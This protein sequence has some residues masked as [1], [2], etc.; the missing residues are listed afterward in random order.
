MGTTDGRHLSEHYIQHYGILIVISSDGAIVGLS[1]NISS[2]IAR[3]DTLAILGTSFSEFAEAHFGYSAQKILLTVDKVRFSQSPRQLILQSI[4]GQIYYLYIYKHSSEVFLEWE[5][6]RRKSISAHEMDELGFLFEKNP[7]EIWNALCR[8]VQKLIQYENVLVWQVLDG[9]EG[10]I[11]AEY[12]KANRTGLKD[13]YFSAEFMP[14]DIVSFY[15]G[16]PYRYCPNTFAE[17]QHFLSLQPKLQLDPCSYLRFPHT[18]ESYLQSMGITSAIVYPIIVRDT[19]WGIILAH[20]KREKHI[21]RQKRKLCSFVVQNAIGKFEAIAQQLLLE[22]REQMKAL[23]LDLKDRLL[24]SDTAN[25]AIAE[26]MPQLCGLVEADGLVLYH[27]GDMRTYGTCPTSIQI[28]QIIQ[29]LHRHSDTRLLQD[30]RFV[31][32]YQDR[33]DHPIPIAGVMALEIGKGEDHYAIWLRKAIVQ[34]IT[35]IGD[36]RSDQTSTRRK[37]HNRS[38]NLKTRAVTIDNLALPWG[39]EERTFVKNLSALIENALAAKAQEQEKHKQEMTSLNKELEMLTFTLSHDLKNPLSIVKM[40]VQFL[41]TNDKLTQEAQRKWYRSILEGVDHIEGIINHL[42][43]LGKTNSYRY[44]KDPVPME[45]MIRALSE[46]AKILNNNPCCEM[47]YGPLLPLWGEK[48]VLYQIF[49]NIIGN[50]IKY[51][52]GRPSP[53]VHIESY[54]K[55]AFVTYAIKDN[56]IGIPEHQHASIFDLFSRASNSAAFNGSGLGLCLV[57]RIMDKI[58]GKIALESQLNIGTTIRLWFP[59]HRARED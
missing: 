33:I 45:Q 14:P 6:Q 5:L 51:T 47:T 24:F 21:D 31:A 46:D 27:K 39:E 29:I 13:T 43:H 53:N 16:S 38:H 42:F 20:N 58:G 36:T 15:E 34:R 54:E 18:H 59:V 52:A 49:L 44:A 12:S 7:S 4:N 9:G 26:I 50:A 32:K 30:H 23:E 11:V 10:K 57:K 2:L 8:A 28:E 40:G 56:G 25:S 19:F 17:H 48:S 22:R 41:E 35:S 37:P 3:D 1:E 55:D